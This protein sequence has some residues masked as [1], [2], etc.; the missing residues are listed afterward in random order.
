MCLNKLFHCHYKLTNDCLLTASVTF[1]MYSV[2]TNKF[3]NLL[4][5]YYSFS[6]TLELFF[7]L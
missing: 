5:S 2:E 3:H 6:E 1:H 7:I 4:E